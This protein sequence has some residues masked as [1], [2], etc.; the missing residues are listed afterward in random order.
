MNDKFPENQ[1]AGEWTLGP[2]SY[3]SVHGDCEESDVVVCSRI[4]LFRNIAEHSFVGVS[5][6]DQLDD[7]RRTITDCLQRSAGLEDLPIIDSQQ[8]REIER[9]FLME[10]QSVIDAA[11]DPD[12]DDDLFDTDRML[13]DQ[14]LFPQSLSQSHSLSDPL[15]DLHDDQQSPGDAGTDMGTG[16]AESDSGDDGVPLGCFPQGLDEGIDHDS[17][18]GVDDRENDRAAGDRQSGRPTDG[19]GPDMTVGYGLPLEEIPFDDLP[20]DGLAG[21]SP[22]NDGLI[23]DGDGVVDDGFSRGVPFDDGLG[24]RSGDG[25]VNAADLPFGAA[26]SSIPDLDAVGAEGRLEALFF[27]RVADAFS[28]ADLECD[29]W[30]LRDFAANACDRLPSHEISIIVNDEDHLR[31]Q[32]QAGGYCLNKMWRAMSELDDRLQQSLNYAFS[33]R[34]GYL[35]SSP[36]NVGTAMRASVLLHLPALA[37]LG[38]L[39]TVFARL[40]RDGIVGRGAFDDAASGH[41]YRIGNQVTLGRTEGSLINRVTCVVPSIVDYEREARKLVLR[42]CHDLIATQSAEACRALKLKV[43]RSEEEWLSLISKIRLGLSLGQITSAQAAEVQSNF[44]LTCLKRKLE[45]AVKL[46]QYASATKYRDR[47]RQLEQR[48][49]GH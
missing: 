1:A 5:S 36:A 43:R 26:D 48:H 37:T 41:F 6:Q 10:L 17:E 47:I 40:K 31:L 12:A 33:P 21:G 8:L 3:Q 38:R 22:V 19:V 45:T 25:L 23:D 11:V 13:F 14:Q 30:G 35:S 46:E 4:Q 44:E 18:H 29:Q 27:D 7:V 32:I 20:I 16:I 49:Y 15:D 34:W 39:D 2:F 42:Q 9:Q 28:M 24:D